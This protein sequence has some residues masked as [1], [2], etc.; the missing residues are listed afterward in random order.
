MKVKNSKRKGDTIS[1]E[2][3]TSA[4]AIK[5]SLDIS[6]KQL[7]KSAKVPGFRQGKVPRKIFE[8][9]YGKEVILKEG[10]TEAVN[11]AYTQAVEELELEVIDYPENIKI[12]EYKEEQPVSFTCEVKVRPEV[13]VG[14]Y[15]GIKV[16]KEPDQVEDKVV[17]DHINQLRESAA[18]FEPTENAIQEGDIVRL[19][20]EATC[21]GE[22]VEAWTRQNM[23]LKVGIANFGEEFDKQV[24]GL[25]NT[26]KKEITVSYD[27]EFQKEDV[28]GKSVKFSVEVLEVRGKNLPELDDEF[29]K[30]V[31]QNQVD[32]YKTFKEELIEKLSTE[33]KKKSEEALKS[34]LIKAIVENT[35]IEIPEV[36]VQNEIKYD[37]DQLTRT[38]QSSNTS[39]DKYLELT[40]QTQEQFQSTLKE[41]A[42]RRLQSELVLDTIA[43]D[44]KIEASEE[45]MKNEI[46]KLVPTA[47]T[48][49]DVEK[50]LSRVNQKGLKK[51]IKRTKTVDFLIENA[52][53]ESKKSK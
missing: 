34:D 51:M 26:D 28:A 18:E 5:E 10:L 6:F 17:D 33:L 4:E 44:E 42:T 15:K 22:S 20:V 48:D 35:K 21:E 40:N 29:A 23:G 19:N 11:T 14:K 13:K 39:I 31:T 8:N 2:I 45:D 53:I 50:E 37:V 41:N 24:V 49:E 38:L 52:K 32:N 1:L 47:K 3:E 9:H 27:A 25:K 46:K 36:M 16:T 7:V 43:K 30:K 12:G